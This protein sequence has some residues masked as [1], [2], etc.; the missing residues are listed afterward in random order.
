MGDGG[1]SLENLEK[2]VVQ[3]AE[4]RGILEH[5]RHLPRLDKFYE[6]V[7][8]LVDEIIIP[9]DEGFNPDLDNIKLEAGDV[10]VTLI[11][12]LHPYNLDLETCLDAAYEKIKNR[13]GKMVAGQFVRDREDDK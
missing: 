8:E 11:N 2:Q 13:T 9:D 12:L 10:L 6:E 5:K 4:E 7:E 3:W 1:L